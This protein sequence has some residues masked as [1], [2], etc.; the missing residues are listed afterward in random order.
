MLNVMPLSLRVQFFMFSH[1][2]IVEILRFDVS[3]YYTV[4]PLNSSCSQL[5]IASSP[6]ISQKNFPQQHLPRVVPFSFTSS[7]LAARWCNSGN[8][9]LFLGKRHLKFYSAVGTFSHYSFII[10]YGH[11]REEVRPATN[12]NS[13]VLPPCASLHKS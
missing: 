10:R 5:F 1:T 3:T 2:N 13:A 4:G 11:L 7:G 9:S 12:A 6:C 8:Q